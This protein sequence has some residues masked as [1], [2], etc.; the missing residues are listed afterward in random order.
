M[1]VAYTQLQESDIR[2]IVGSYDLTM[3]DYEPIAVRRSNSNYLLRAQQGSY[4]LTVFGDKTFAQIVE[5][6]RL[7]SLLKEYA[8][9]TPRPLL[10]VNGKMAIMHKARPVMMKEYVAGQVYRHPNKTMLHQVGRAIAELHQVP[11]PGFL[12]GGEPYG[13]QKLSSIQGQEIDTEYEGWI[14][15]RLPYLEQQKPQG[16][17]RGLIHGDIFYDNVLFKGTR[18]AAIID[19]EDA[20][21]EDKVFDL[22]MGIVGLCRKGQEVVLEKA[23]ALVKGYEQIRELEE[24]EKRAL[25][26][27]VEYAATTVS[28]WRYW[29]YHVDAPSVENADKHWQMVRVAEGVQDIPKAR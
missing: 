13:V 20:T 26:L 2:E 16:L 15:K 9:P 19:F 14:A 7:L 25:Q 11:W 5:L 29:Q 1:M 24:G 18:L 17:P 10:A 8:F 6:G 22:G 3:V 12:S 4:V 28:C 21:C 27:Y 23:R